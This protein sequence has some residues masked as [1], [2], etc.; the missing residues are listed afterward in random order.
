MMKA[1]HIY[2][3]NKNSVV[4]VNTKMHCKELTE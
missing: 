1:N 4:S 3:P 2:Y